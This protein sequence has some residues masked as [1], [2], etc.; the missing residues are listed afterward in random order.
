MCEKLREGRTMGANSLVIVAEGTLNRHGNPIT[1]QQVQQI[2]TER[3]GEEARVTSL[4]HVQRG[5]T[6]SSYDRWMST[7]L[8]YTAAHEIVTADDSTHPMIV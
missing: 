4:G 8:G 2:L 1:A 7:L 3:L 6:P 5:G